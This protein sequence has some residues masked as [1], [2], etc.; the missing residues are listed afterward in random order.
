M[1][2]LLLRPQGEGASMHKHMPGL[3]VYGEEEC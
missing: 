1:G 2:Q 3:F